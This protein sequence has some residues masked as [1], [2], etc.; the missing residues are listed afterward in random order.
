MLI[1]ILIGIGYKGGVEN[2]VN[3]TASFFVH[4][5]HKVRIVQLVEIGYHWVVSGID[6]YTLVQAG[7]YSPS[8]IDAYSEHYGFF[9]KK[10]KLPEV[11]LATGWP[12]T[13]AIAKKA[14]K[15]IQCDAPVISWLH[16]SIDAYI[17]AGLGGYRELKSADAHLAINKKIANQLMERTSRHVIEVTNSID[18]SRIVYSDSR[19][20]NKLAYVGRIAQE[21]NIP[22]LLDVLKLS[23]P[24]WTLDVIGDSDEI[25]SGVRILRDYCKQIGVEDRVTFHGWIDNPW[26][27]L[28]DTFAL[29][30]PSIHEGS[31]L[32]AVEAMLCGMPVI[33]TP[34]DGIIDKI[35][36]GKNG[37]LFPFNDKETLLKILELAGKGSLPRMMSNEIRETVIHISGDR[38]LEDMLEKVI[39]F[40]GNKQ[41]LE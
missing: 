13:V 16:G 39:A 41:E 33:A 18:T 8:E 40:V 34:T 11:V 30:L 27:L 5:G 4:S 9:L 19:D 29:V 38:P 24:E 14:L 31:P 36:P 26:E 21:K 7:K 17:E 20:T 25:G 12:N 15:S 3:R 35:I 1:D 32:V 2:V 22:F 10:S 37:Y 6:F 28:T 23:S